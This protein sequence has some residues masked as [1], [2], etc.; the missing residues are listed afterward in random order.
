[1]YIYICNRGV[2]CTCRTISSD[3]HAASAPALM[4]TL[5]K[6]EAVRSVRFGAHACT[7]GV[8]EHGNLAEGGGD[9]VLRQAEVLHEPLAVYVGH[10]YVHKINTH[11]HTHTYIH[12]YTYI[13]P[14]MSDTCMCTR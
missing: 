1:M 2:S 14:Y 11:T 10:L 6:E 7:L 5:P 13:V 4:A 9:Q 3:E 12:V 8:L